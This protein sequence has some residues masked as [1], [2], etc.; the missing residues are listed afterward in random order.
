MRQYIIHYSTNKRAKISLFT[1]KILFMLT[2]CSTPESGEAS[3]LSFFYSMEGT[4]LEPGFLSIKKSVLFLTPVWGG[5][6][7]ASQ[8]WT[9]SQEAYM[10]HNS[11]IVQIIL[12]AFCLRN[13]FALS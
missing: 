11:G 3:F 9:S 8:L 13:F 10:N 5:G 1:K 2:I 7:R 6:G 4:R 12:V